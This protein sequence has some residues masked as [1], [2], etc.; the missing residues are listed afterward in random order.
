MIELPF[1]VLADF[2]NDRVQAAA[3]PSDGAMLNGEIGALI[4]IVGMKKIFPARPRNR[5]HVLDCGEG[6]GFFAHRS[7]IA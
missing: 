6:C 3:H 4:G 2:K 7:G 5:F 1:G